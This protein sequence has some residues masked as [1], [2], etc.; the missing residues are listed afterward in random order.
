[1]TA[2]VRT[3]VKSTY[4]EHISTVGSID[5][6]GTLKTLNSKLVL[7][8]TSSIILSTSNNKANKANK[9]PTFRYFLV[10]SPLPV[11]LNISKKM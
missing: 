7:T 4:L 9:V 6:I 1:M 2:K 5:S 10:S 3:D 11:I 8:S